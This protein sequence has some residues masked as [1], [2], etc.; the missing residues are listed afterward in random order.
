MKC[1]SSIASAN[2]FAFQIPLQLI[3]EGSLANPILVIPVLS[4]TFAS[5]DRMLGTSQQKHSG[6]CCSM[7][8]AGDTSGCMSDGRVLFPDKLQL[9]E[10]H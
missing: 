4:T 10:N 9:F 3:S 2:S 7:K 8:R 1:A 6:G 5:V